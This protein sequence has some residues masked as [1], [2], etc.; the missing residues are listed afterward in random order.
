MFISEATPATFLGHLGSLQTNVG[1][2]GQELEKVK[3]YL[4]LKADKTDVNVLDRKQKTRVITQ[5]V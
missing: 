4:H 2:D 1:T 3:H 5:S